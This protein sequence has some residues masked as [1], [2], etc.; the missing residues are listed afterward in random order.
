[1][2]QSSNYSR[3]TYGRGGSGYRYDSGGSEIKTILLFYLLPFIVVNAFIFFLVMTTP[4]SEIT[5][6]ESSD[7][8]STTVGITVKSF[9][10]IST[11]VVTLVGEPIEVKKLSRNTYEAV[12][13]RNG[14][15]QVDVASINKMTNTVFD[16]I[17]VL[18]DSPPSI[19]DNILEDNILSFKVGDAQSGVDYGS[20]LASN[21]TS[22]GILPLSIDRSTG[23]ITFEMTGDTL[24]VS[25]KDLLG[26]ENHITFSASGESTT[27]PDGAEDTAAV[28]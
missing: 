12:L 15:L 24:D 7:Y 18:D 4:K 9:L 13:T 3:Q 6:G 16:Q 14:V 2:R 25:V 10:P 1:M 20:I 23:I 22:T 26:N 19:Q 11:P 17:N 5:V 21:E 28:E 8:I 27:S